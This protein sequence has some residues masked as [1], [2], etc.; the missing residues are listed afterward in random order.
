MLEETC[1]GKRVQF[2]FI[3][4]CTWTRRFTLIPHPIS[5]DNHDEVVLQETEAD[6]S[7]V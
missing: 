6:P 7:D 3:Y 1:L 4:A 2:Y 5:L